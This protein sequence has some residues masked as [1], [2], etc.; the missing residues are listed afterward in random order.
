MDDGQDAAPTKP[1]SRSDEILAV[2]AQ[3]FYQHGYNA[4]GMRM[5]ADAAG[6]RPASIYHHFASKQEMLYN[7]TLEV[8]RDFIDEHLL[9]LS[10]DGHPADRFERLVSLHIQYFWAHRFSMS[11]GLRE[12]RNLSPENFAEVRQVRLRYQHGIRD[13]IAA[14]VASGAF[15]CEDPQLVGLAVLDMIN[16]VNGWFNEQGRYSIEQLADSHARMIVRRLLG[17]GE[18]SDRPASQPEEV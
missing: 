11:V 8:T 3:L 9:I 13:F 12:M 5:I 6:V 14:G 17:A 18:P 16:G 15:V 2:A 7:L 4:V 10:G 1:V